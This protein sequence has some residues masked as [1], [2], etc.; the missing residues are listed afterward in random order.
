MV[1]VNWLASAACAGEDPK[2]FDQYSF[3]G[4]QEAVRICG[5]CRVVDECLDW[6]KPNKSWFDGVS[7]GIVWRNGYRVRVDNTTREDRFV[8]LRNERGDVENH[9]CIPEIHGQGT[10]PFD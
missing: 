4:A 9:A 10:L 6:V 3:P 5:N 1:L 8:R 2:L 7:A